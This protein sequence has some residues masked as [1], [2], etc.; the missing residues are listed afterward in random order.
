MDR[1]LNLVLQAGPDQIRLT[2][3]LYVAPYIRAPCQSKVA[4][5][6]V[7]SPITRCNSATPFASTWLGLG[8]A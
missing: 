1:G 8:L 7:P 5:F 4:S 2:R 6:K 3:F